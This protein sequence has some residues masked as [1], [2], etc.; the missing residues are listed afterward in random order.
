MFIIVSHV[1][2]FSH[3]NAILYARFMFWFTYSIS[4]RS[5]TVAIEEY[6]VNEY[7]TRKLN[8]PMELA[9]NIFM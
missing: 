5:G 4:I 1:T 8:N 6:I 2:Y 9:V 7:L 3:I